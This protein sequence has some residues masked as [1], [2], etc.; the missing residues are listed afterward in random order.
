MEYAHLAFI[1]KDS[2]RGDKTH[3]LAERLPATHMTTVRVKFVDTHEDAVRRVQ[4]YGMKY[5]S[6]EESAFT[7]A[8]PIYLRQITQVLRGLP[9]SVSLRRLVFSFLTV[10]MH[11]GV[12]ID[13]NRRVRPWISRLLDSMHADIFLSPSVRR[14]SMRRQRQ[15]AHS[16]QDGFVTDCEEEAVQEHEQADTCDGGWS[17]VMRSSLHYRDVSYVQTGLPCDLLF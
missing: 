4:E 3:R 14:S 11:P 10:R 6:K 7:V 2:G 16:S 9:S 5:N 17:L 13:H 15:Q 8:V 1:F 12:T